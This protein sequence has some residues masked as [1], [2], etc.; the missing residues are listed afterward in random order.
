[1]N[2]RQQQFLNLYR[3]FRQ[4]DQALFY[5]AR[6]DEFE[7]AHNQAVIL[8]ALLMALTA[9]VASLSL[10]KFEPKWVAP[11]LGVLLPALSA[12]LTA[13]NSLYSFEQQAKLYQDALLALRKAEASGF[14]AEQAAEDEAEAKLAAYVNLV[15][16]VFRKEQGQWGQLIS[17]LKPVEPPRK[18]DASPTPKLPKA[19]GTAQTTDAKKPDKLA[20]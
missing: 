2:E 20:V 6:C 14:D 17:D 3:A 12:A 11:V 9:I 13:Y 1:M 19:P 15:E 10:M 5:Q 18:P 16:G 4:K 7:Q 8:A